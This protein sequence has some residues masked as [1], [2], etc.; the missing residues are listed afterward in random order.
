MLSA[1]RSI[2]IPILLLL[3]TTLEVTGDAVVRLALYNHVSITRVALLLLGAAL[4]L[5]YGSLV[6]TPPVEF[7]R[8]VGLYVATLLIV[9]QVIS[10]LVFR[11]LPALPVWVGGVLVVAGGSIIT[12]WRAA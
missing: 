1:L 9:W 4:L 6:N 10:F 3:A 2:P 5:G 8:V 11:T 12:F 7:G